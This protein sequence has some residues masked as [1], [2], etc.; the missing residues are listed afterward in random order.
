M[1]VV[2]VVWWWSR[3]VGVGG[4]YSEQADTRQE[5]ESAQGEKGSH[6]LARHRKL[7]QEIHQQILCLGGMDVTQLVVFVGEWRTQEDISNMKCCL[8]QVDGHK[9]HV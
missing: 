1:K 2:L 9:M 8:S 3:L 6:H 5:K 7:L 4:E